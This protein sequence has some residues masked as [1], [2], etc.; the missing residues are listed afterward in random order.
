MT[1]SMFLDSFSINARAVPSTQVA[2][3]K[4]AVFLYSD[5][6]MP[7]RHRGVRRPQFIRRLSPDRYLTIGERQDHPLKRSC[8]THNPWIHPDAPAGSVERIN[9][10]D[11]PVA[12]QRFRTAAE[13]LTSDNRFQGMR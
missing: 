11:D 3:N 12:S 10:L 9:A 13:S 1:E 5:G 7:S 4:L 8:N 2:Q 6:A